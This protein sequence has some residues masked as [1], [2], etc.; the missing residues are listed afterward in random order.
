MVLFKSNGKMTRFLIFMA[1]ILVLLTS[2]CGKENKDEKKVADA[3]KII[4]IGIAN[5]ADSIAMTNILKVVLEEELGYTVETKSADLAVIFSSIAQQDF[6][7]YADTW[8]PVTHKT[9]VDKFKDQLEIISPTFKDARI[10]LVVPKYVT[11]DSISELN[12]HKEKFELG[13]VGIDTG[14]GIMKK[15]EEAIQAYNLDMGLKASSGPVMT[16]I[17]KRAIDKNEWVVVTG[18][19]PHWKFA[20]WE[21]KFLEDPKKSYGEV[22]TVYAV[23]HAGFRQDFPD[24]TTLLENF[25]LTDQQ[26]GEVMGLMAESEADPY[27]VTKQWVHANGDT[28]KKWL[29]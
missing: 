9:Y 19:K 3:K 13:I 20:R 14:A 2:A 6:D 1:A 11:I 17:L 28:V 7:L 21:L 16:A 5:Y 24:V 15:T 8:L 12:A 23:G 25:I 4:R 22:E 27:E 18:W 10:G 26:L 29:K